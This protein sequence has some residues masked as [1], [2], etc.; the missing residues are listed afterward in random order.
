VKTLY[1]GNPDC[2]AKKI[3]SAAHFASRDAINI[4]GLSEATVERFVSAGFIHSLADFF[5]LARYQEEIE[6][7]EGFGKKSYA[8]LQKSIEIARKTTP[9]RF[10]YSLGITGVGLA[11]AKQICAHCGQ[12]IERAM[13]LS[14]DELLQVNGIGEV[15][16]ADY[17]AFFAEETNVSLSTA[18]LAQLHID[19]PAQTDPVAAPLVGKA[20]VITGSLTQFANRAALKEAIESAG[21]RTVSAVSEKTDY[22][23]NND[24]N[25]NSTKNKTAKQLGIPI[26]TEDEI[27]EMIKGTL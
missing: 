27:V 25:S 19:K 13:K 11:T 17:T 26:V 18:L 16:A 8:N 4:E 10:L 21:G 3:K 9:S 24:I 6:S 2:F 14:V 7:M 1:C 12:D 22:L 5:R 20:F 23:V 15:I